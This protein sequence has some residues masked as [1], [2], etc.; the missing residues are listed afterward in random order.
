MAQRFGGVGVQLPLNQI[1]TNGFELQAGAV[2]YIPSGTW[3]I[4]HGPYTTV[5]VLDPV[6]GVWRPAGDDTQSFRQVDSDGFN[7]R[8]AN[9]TGCPVAAMVTNAGSGYT[10]A[11]TV[12]AGAGSPKLQA[13]MGTGISTTVTVTAGGSNY[14]DPP[15]GN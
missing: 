6:T 14:T 1:G 4:K 10:S 13:I 15:L 9:Q 7:Y 12:T 3:N 2:F 11:P 8:L 5:Q